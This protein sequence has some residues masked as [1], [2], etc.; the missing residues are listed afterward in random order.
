MRLAAQQ[1]LKRQETERR[2]LE[3]RQLSR[4]REVAKRH[5]QLRDAES[6]DA[7]HTFPSV[8][9]FYLFDSVKPFWEKDDGVTLDDQTWTSQLR[10]IKKQIAAFV[11]QKRMEITKQ[12]LM[13]TTSA[14]YSTLS[15]TPADYSPTHYP[16]SWYDQVTRRFLHQSPYG[17]LRLIKYPDVLS[18]NRNSNY[19][20]NTYGY[21]QTSA[22]RVQTIRAIL[23]AAELDEATATEADLDALDGRLHWKQ[24]PKS[25][26]K[27]RRGS[28]F[29][30]KQ[31]VSSR[32][33]LPCLGDRSRYL[34]SFSRRF[35]RSRVPSAVR[36][37]IS[38][39]LSPSRLIPTLFN[40]RAPE[41]EAT[42]WAR[43]RTKSEGGAT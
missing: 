33:A 39:S 21:L 10:A 43:T 32:S 12:I 15:N 17:S 28:G 34:T 13:A 14:N 8:E 27:W 18:T 19:V 23:S 11:A 41:L 25:R 2:A 42:K 9:H 31:L 30:W 38:V 4:K 7:L 40:R 16:S 22:A 20:Y 6:G 37:G 24:Q 5:R 26:K 35:S 29:R 3:A 36:T 1:R